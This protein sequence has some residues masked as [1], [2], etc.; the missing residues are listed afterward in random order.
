MDRFSFMAYINENFTLSV[1]AQRLVYD[2]LFYIEDNFDDPEDQKAAAKELLDSI[3]LSDEEY[4]LI[5]F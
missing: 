2:I 3:G 5:K 1:Q 4:N